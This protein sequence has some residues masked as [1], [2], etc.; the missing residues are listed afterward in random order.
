[1]GIVKKL[2]IPGAAL[3][4]ACSGDGA[5]FPTEPTSMVGP[6]PL[7]PGPTAGAQESDA[8]LTVADIAESLG[9]E[10]NSSFIAAMQASVAIAAHDSADWPP[11]LFRPSRV[12]YFDSRACP[13]DRL[14]GQLQPKRE[15]TGSVSGVGATIVG[16]TLSNTPVTFTDRTHSLRGRD[17][18]YHGTLVAAGAWTASDPNSPVSLSGPVTVDTIGIVPVEGSTGAY[19]VGT[20]GEVRVGRPDMPPPP[21]PPPPPCTGPGGVPVPCP[22]PTPGEVNV[23]GNWV[24]AGAGADARAFRLQQSGGTITGTFAVPP[25]LGTIVASQPSQFERLKPVKSFRFSTG[26]P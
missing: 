16:V 11:S 12:V 9:A 6:S 26:D 23:T 18:T 13:G 5:G 7:A 17:V 1:M 10:I 15:R 22:G 21:N 4:I 25:E 8:P 24:A 20:I 3:A 19:F 2:L 14:H